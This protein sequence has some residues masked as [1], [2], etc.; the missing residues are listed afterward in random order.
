MDCNEGTV[1]STAELETAAPETQRETEG[2]CV[3]CR[4]LATLLG[5]WP[6]PRPSAFAVSLEA[7]TF[8]LRPEETACLKAQGLLAWVPET[9]RHR[10]R[11]KSF[12]SAMGSEDF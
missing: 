5:G 3:W 7:I 12:Y 9:A 11:K 8:Q 6:R 1:I 4:I 10:P 2:S